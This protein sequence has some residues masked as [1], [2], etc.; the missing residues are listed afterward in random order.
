M[1]KERLLPAYVTERRSTSREVR[2]EKVRSKSRSS[3]EKSLEETERKGKDFDTKKDERKR[4]LNESENEGQSAKR[5]KSEVVSKVEPDLAEPFSD[6]GESDDELLSK[7]V[8]LP[9]NDDNEK[10]EGE[11]VEEELEEGEE[12]KEEGE[13]EDDDEEEEGEAN[14]SRSSSRSNNDNMERKRKSDGL[15]EGI[16]DED[17]EAISEEDEE[18]EAKSTKAKMADALGVDW[19]QMLAVNNEEKSETV[20][21]D[22]WSPAAMLNKLGLAKTFLSE[23]AYKK[24]V[25]SVNESVEDENKK[26]NPSHDVA[27]VDVSR[28]KRVEERKILFAQMG[29]QTTA[30]TTRK[31]TDIR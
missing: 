14:S 8:A 1:S 23:K 12:R 27:L 6:F 7:E 25:Q 13:A 9:E 29:R 22:K 31:D 28:R 10:E 17:L 30:L 24:I 26:F 18:K 3:R 4:T 20:K 16:S 11:A 19:S 2:E 21:S 15:L 5:V